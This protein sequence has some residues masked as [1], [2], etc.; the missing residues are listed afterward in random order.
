LIRD[1]RAMVDRGRA[2]ATI[3]ADL[4]LHADVLFSKWY[5]VRDGTR[6]RPWL[7]REVEWIRD[8]V[9]DLLR[10]GGVCAC[11]KT[12]AVCREMLAVEE[13]MWTFASVEGVEP[14]NNA[15]ERAVRPVVLWRKRSFGTWSEDGCRYVE[16]LL[17]VTHTLRL[18]GRRVLDSLRDALV[19]HR[20]GLP[21]P[22][23]L[24]E[25]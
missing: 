22:Q 2:G 23:L 24:L 14:T 5:R 3:G 9:V 8:A 7:I 1:F 21:T 18:Q 13:A 12:A 16:R 10:R 20:A 4:L 17:T 11:A 19:A 6:K 15:A 25:G